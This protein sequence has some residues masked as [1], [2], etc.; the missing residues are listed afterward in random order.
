MKVLLVIAALVLGAQAGNLVEELQK[1]NVS[2][3][4]QLATTA[5]LADSLTNGGK[6][7]LLSYAVFE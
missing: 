7:S 3:L 1:L 5:G 2:T 6:L 4:I